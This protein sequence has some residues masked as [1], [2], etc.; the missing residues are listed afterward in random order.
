M[1]HSPSTRAIR[2]GQASA[3]R[4]ASAH[5]GSGCIVLKTKAAPP[6]FLSCLLPE[7]PT[8]KTH[9]NVCPPPATLAEGPGRGFDLGPGA[10]CGKL[11]AARAWEQAQ[12]SQLAP[13]P[14]A[15]GAGAQRTAR[16]TRTKCQSHWRKA[17]DSQVQTVSQLLAW[18]LES[19]HAFPRG[20][21]THA[22]GSLSP[23]VNQPVP[24][25][26][27]FSHPSTKHT[28]SSPPRRHASCWEGKCIHQSLWLAEYSK[29]HPEDT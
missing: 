7:S 1:A 8:A 22:P 9:R 16:G 6:R 18:M 3:S 27:S 20:H 23:V 2:P 21:K 28:E 14:A 13:S 12:A 24:A 11:A 15:L 5:L 10:Q 4:R 17:P 29:P 26:F 19:A 25:G